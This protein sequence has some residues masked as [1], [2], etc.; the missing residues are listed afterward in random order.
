MVKNN[1]NLKPL[2]AKKP[3]ETVQELKNDYKVPSCEEFMENYETDGSLNYDD[4]SDNSLWTPKGYG[5]CKNT[6]CGCSCSSETCTC[7]GASAWLKGA[8]S[9]GSAHFRKSDDWRNPDLNGQANASAFSVRDNDVEARFLGGTA[10]FEANLKSTKV[11]LSADVYNVKTDGVQLRVGP[12][13][14]TGFSVEDGLEAK[15]GGFGFSVGKK[16]GISTPI[17]ELTVD[18]EDKCVIQ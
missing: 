13:V 11:R 5:P 16:T 18:T 7:K 14:D 2:V 17:G 12:S 3:F 9:G 10:S 15:V 6:L 1:E 4:L 8:G